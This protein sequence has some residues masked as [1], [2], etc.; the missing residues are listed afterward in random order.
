MDEKYISDVVEFVKELTKNRYDVYA[1]QQMKNNSVIVN[2]ICIH[3]KSSNLSP[4]IHIDSFF[5]SGMTAYETAVKV[6][7]RYDEIRGTE[8][9]FDVRN[10]MDFKQMQDKVAY[11][12]INI[13]ANAGLLEE[14][15]YAEVTDDLALIYYLELGNGTVTI[16]DT[17]MEIWGVTESVLYDMADYNTQRIHPPTLEPMNI[18][19]VDMFKSTEDFYAVKYDMGCEDMTDEEFRQVLIERMD[20]GNSLPTNTIE[21]YVLRGGNTYG[22]SV[23][24]YEDV[25]NSLYEYFGS[26]YYIFP[27]S[28]YELM[29]FPCTGEY[30]ISTLRSMVQSVDEQIL[31]PEDILSDS[32]YV[33]NEKG[34]SIVVSDDRLNNTRSEDSR[35][36]D[37][38]R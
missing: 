21:A 26:E 12:L 23:L 30:D 38:A 28:I 7:E 34:L 35:L 2:G 3:S 16:S 5:E 8:I 11:R 33:F 36:Y 25:L 32:V 20:D 17:L 22:A 6:V 37:E 10:L 24:M 31:S 4:I 14:V 27:S 15:P 19:T 1:S 13:E 9:P 18:V 29:I